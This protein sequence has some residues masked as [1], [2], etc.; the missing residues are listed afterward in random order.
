[1]TEENA[2]ASPSTPRP[3]APP[4]P[5]IV[6][7]K[8]RGVSVVWV[9]PI[10]AGLLGLWLVWQHYVGQGPLVEVRFETGEGVQAGKTPV[11]CRNVNVGRVE[12]MKLSKDLKEVITQLR[13]NYEDAGILREETRFWVVRPRLGGSGFSGLGTLVSG[14]Y[15]EIDPS[16]KG[17]PRHKFKGLENPPVTPQG[18]PGLHVT[19]IA[20]KAGALGAGS[21]VSYKGIRVGRIESRIFNAT[22]SKV[23][24]AAFIEGDYGK[25]ITNKTRFW[26]ESGIDFELGSS[27]IKLRTGTLES[28]VTGGVAFDAV[29][30][31][32]PAHPARDDAIYR[33][34][35]S[36]DATNETVIK[37]SLTYLLLFKESVRGLSPGAPVEFRGIRV[38]SV[39]D[40]SFTYLPDDPER[41][42][43]VLIRIDPGRIGDFPSDD[44]E[45]GAAMMKES[46]QHGLRASLKTG[47]L[48]TGQLFVG[49]DFQN[50]LPLA[51]VS[52]AGDYA[53]IP[54]ISTGLAQLQDKF[55]AL[56]DKVQ[57]LP[58]E[59]TVSNA[60]E[61]LAELKS[62]AKN[63]DKL[64]AS[65]HTQGIPAELNASLAQ[66]TKTVE[67]F[68]Q[69][70]AIYRDLSTALQEMSDTLRSV[71]SLANTLE[72]K[73]NSLLFGRPS[74]VTTP[75]RGSPAFR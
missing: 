33:L 44:P 18:V 2:S 21:S 41:R 64:L 71:N 46:V 10:V 30:G 15:I 53:M 74:G 38:G 1:M 9:V 72:R 17:A 5:K 36:F 19:L 73:P 39:A 42:I 23:E 61:T 59:T 50:A 57:A 14:T 13:I 69:N 47:S 55:I 62:A 34:Y 35:E 65:D 4:A 16:T 54:T 22:N 6:R 11:L 52:Q 66:L 27:G 20:D 29:E 58:I 68:N 75:P 43:P 32:G 60:N 25:L 7:K 56:L 48:L 8:R 3:A 40:I 63:L 70:S 24:F 31:A 51:E 12:S 49:L 28:I 67:G 26:N 45:K 37:P